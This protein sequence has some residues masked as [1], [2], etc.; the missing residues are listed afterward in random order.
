[1]KSNLREKSREERFDEVFQIVL[2]IVALSFDILWV[3]GRTPIPEIAVFIFALSFWAIGNLKG[4]VWEY[5][6]KLGS[7][8]LT[9]ILFTNFYLISIHGDLAALGIWE[10]VWGALLLP[11]LCT[12]ITVSLGQYLKETIDRS[13]TRDILIGGTLGYMISMSLLFMFG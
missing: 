8:N 10:M 1:M 9:I 4:G 13:L 7:F 5:P 2:I 11:L 12:V 3:S 6:L